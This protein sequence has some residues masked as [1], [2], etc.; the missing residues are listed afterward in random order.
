MTLQALEISPLPRHMQFRDVDSIGSEP[1]L[2]KIRRERYSHTKKGIYEMKTNS[3]LQPRARLYLIPHLM[4]TLFGE[5]ILTSRDSLELLQVF[6]SALRD[7][8]ESQVNDVETKCEVTEIHD[9]VRSM[10]MDSFEAFYE[11]MLFAA[12][13]CVREARPVEFPQ[14]TKAMSTPYDT[15]NTALLVF[16]QLLFLI[17][18]DFERHE[19]KLSTFFCAN[20][21]SVCLK[22]AMQLCTIL[23]EK[24]TECL[25]FRSRN[26]HPKAFKAYLT[27]SK[28]HSLFQSSN[29]VFV[30]IERICQGV[31]KGSTSLVKKSG[32]KNSGRR[33]FINIECVKSVPKAV[34]ELE[35][36]RTHLQKC[37]GLLRIDRIEDD[38]DDKIEKFRPLCEET[39]RFVSRTNGVFSVKDW[40]SQ[41]SK[42]KTQIQVTKR[43][44]EEIENVS[45]N[46]NV[47]DSSSRSGGSKFEARVRNPSKQRR[48]HRFI[49]EGTS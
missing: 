11:S 43:S 47:D 25:N 18:V 1:W 15:I 30:L 42:R 24:I 3:K 12:L 9:F 2:R 10:S 26:D 39:R 21:L 48:I 40:I 35:K 28:L 22:T 31:K 41:M 33:K 34:L 32:K 7:F 37:L 16:R 17:V 29:R 20:S 44:R 36:C 27:T 4:F 46:G 8:L 38:Q 13:Y 45:R 14:M 23:K 5:D 19:N 49:S 6:V